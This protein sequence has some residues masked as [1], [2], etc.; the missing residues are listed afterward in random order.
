[1]TRATGVRRDRSASERAWNFSAGPAT[2]PLPVLERVRDELLS[3][4]GARASILEISH[5]SKAFEAIAE[6][7][8]SNLRGLLAIPDAHHVLFLQGGASLQFAMAPMNLLGDR[9]AQY[10]ITGSWGRRALA[11]A[12]TV[13]RADA[14]WDGASERD[15]DVP[16]LGSLTLDP[17]A[18]YVHITSNETIGGVQFPPDAVS[19]LRETPTL[20]CD[21]SSD[22]LSRPI[23]APR[24]GLM[25][26]GAQKNA[27]P[28]GLTVVALD[29]ALTERIGSGLPAILDYGT[30]VEHRSLFN[31]PPTFAIYVLMHVT[32]WLRDDVGGLAP[33]A[34]RNEEKASLLYEAIDGSGGFYRGHARPAARS[35]MNATWRLADEDLERRFLDEA[36]ANDLL[37]LRGH[38]SVGGIRA[39]IYNAMPIEGVRALRSFMDDFARRNG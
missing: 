24:Y 31:T 38:R 30:H 29:G 21:L 23:D 8:G 9:V 35:R 13:G 36:R 25:Y 19:R 14:V 7:A 17:A 39:S 11:E 12:R 4:P 20:V 26:A 34:S 28:A 16:D 1:M 2:L 18:A 6:E 32:R 33:M 15:T 22:F 3:L 37:E 27:G 5:R 10:V